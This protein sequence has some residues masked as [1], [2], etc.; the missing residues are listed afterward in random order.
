M[1]T[2]ELDPAV[3]TAAA[4]GIAAICHECSGRH[5]SPHMADARAALT[6]AYPL[7]VADKDA[8]INRMRGQLDR[9][10]HSLRRSNLR[11][12]RLTAERDEAR[13]AIDAAVAERLAPIEALAVSLPNLLGDDAELAA[14]VRDHIRAALSTAKEGC[15]GNDPTCPCQDG[16][17]CHYKTYGD[18]PAM[19][20]PPPTAKA[21]SE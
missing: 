12:D 2:P 6:A 8:E 1:T 16:D 15:A 14:S 3:V 11:I 20:I 4:L 9:A 13:A 5:A 21:A 17:A 18:S 19:E 7:F 10:G